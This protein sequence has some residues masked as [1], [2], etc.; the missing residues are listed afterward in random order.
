KSRILPMSTS[1][2]APFFSAHAAMLSRTSRERRMSL[3]SCIR[4][5]VDF[6]LTPFGHVPDW[7]RKHRYVGVANHFLGSGSKKY[8]VHAALFAH[9]QY[10]EINCILIR[11]PRD[12]VSRY[13]FGKNGF[14]S[15]LS[16]PCFSLDLLECVPR[17]LH[18]PLLF[19]IADIR[20]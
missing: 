15:H 12:R 4:N 8:S 9:R 6:M 19:G 7:N 16:G 11:D 20:P 14:N 18:K 17:L 2:T 1:S 13:S 5:F 3:C 10:D